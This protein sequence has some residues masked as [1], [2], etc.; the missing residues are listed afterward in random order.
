VAIAVLLLVAQFDAAPARGELI[1]EHSSVA[2]GGKVVVAVRV[3]M[4]PKWH[5]YWH[6]SGDSGTPTWVTWKAPEGVIV[7]P[8]RWPAP[9]LV[10][11]GEMVMYGWE[12]E[13]LL[14]AE[15]SV[16]KDFAGE[17]VRIVAKADWL[18]CAEICLEGGV[19]DSVELPVKQRGAGAVSRWKKAFAAMRAAMPKDP[20]E[21]AI[22]AEAAPALRLDNGKL[23]I[24]SGT[25]AWFYPRESGV[26]AYA[27]PQ[28]LR[29]GAEHSVLALPRPASMKDQR[30]ERLAGVLVLRDGEV[31][32]AF[33]VDVP[34]PKKG[35]LPE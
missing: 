4:D 11:D 29:R 8:L 12:K 30:I 24:G 1:A 34:V 7:K 5:I 19:T 20:P 10:K 14:G 17:S 2:P 21:R 28:P 27:K 3:E 22:T 13:V 15:V 16:P 31:R 9:H 6:N 32:R 35:E 33:L 23:G 26:V 25:Q 18:V